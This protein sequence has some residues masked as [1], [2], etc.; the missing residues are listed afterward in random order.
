M[1]KIYT[2]AGRGGTSLFNVSVCILFNRTEL[3]SKG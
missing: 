1:L 2:K 3:S